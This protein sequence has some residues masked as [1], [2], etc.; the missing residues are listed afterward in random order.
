MCT[1]CTSMEQVYSNNCNDISRFFISTFK[2]VGCNTTRLNITLLQTT[3]DLRGYLSKILLTVLKTSEGTPNKDFASL[4]S[5]SFLSK[6]IST[7]FDR[8]SNVKTFIF[9]MAILCLNQFYKPIHLRHLASPKVPIFYKIIK[10]YH[11]ISM[12]LWVHYF[13][14]FKKWF[15]QW[16][17]KLKKLSL[18][19]VRQSTKYS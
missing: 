18:R 5:K 13:D 17:K 10:L 4:V 8:V 12:K 14:I 15:K 2:F 1:V 3:T 6:S 11:H 16:C 7:F 19:G 9:L